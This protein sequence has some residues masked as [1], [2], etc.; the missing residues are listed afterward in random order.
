[1][2]NVEI[3]CGFPIVR[4]KRMCDH[5]QNQSPNRLDDENGDNRPITCDN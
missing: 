2:I 4:R 3:Y 1:M 5:V